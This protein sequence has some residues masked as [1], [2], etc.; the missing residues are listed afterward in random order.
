MPMT[1]IVPNESYTT[2]FIILGFSTSPNQ[3]VPLFLFFLYIYLFTVLSNLV[4]I[5]LICLDRNLH[6][7]MYFFLRNM[8][9]L[10]IFFTSVTAPGLLHII[11][12]ENKRVSFRGFALPVSISIS[13]LSYCSTNQIN[14]I[15]CDITPLLKIAC[16][17]TSTTELI[18]FVSGALIALNCLILTVT[19]YVF[20]IVAILR[21]SSSK[22]RMKTFS[23]CAS[24]LTA[25]FLFYASAGSIYMKPSSSTSYSLDEE[26]PCLVLFCKH[27][28]MLNPIID[29]LR[30]RESY[31][32]LQ[33]YIGHL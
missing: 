25:V 1:W 8:S 24:H 2:Q 23:T 3:K 15:Y 26:S 20:I 16:D 5:V 29:T 21:I 33:N 9:V 31:S 11:L 7:P 30:N 18:M 19:S 22:G 32:I 14:H 6:K 12:S 13:A 4:I 28:P 27:Y 17:D 10:D